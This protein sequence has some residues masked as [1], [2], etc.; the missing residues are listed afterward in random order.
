MRT[1]V[2][3][4]K[5]P[6]IVKSEDVYRKTAGTEWG[7]IIQKR[8]LKWFGKVIRADESTLVTRAFIYAKSDFRN[9]NLT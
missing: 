5:W 6:N 8:I 1:Y 2:L 9:L 7:N 3:N 4:V